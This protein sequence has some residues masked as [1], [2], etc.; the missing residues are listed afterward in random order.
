[1]EESRIFDTKVAKCREEPLEFAIKG[2]KR[3]CLEI[4]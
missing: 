1:M 4:W 2:K 3:T